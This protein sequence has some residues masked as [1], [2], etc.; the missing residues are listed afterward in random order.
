VELIRQKQ[1]K[2]QKNQKVT[3]KC[4]SNVQASESLSKA[5]DTE[6]MMVRDTR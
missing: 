4:L 5:V 3:L 1:E 6:G 2:A